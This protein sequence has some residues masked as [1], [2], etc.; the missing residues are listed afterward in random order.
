MKEIVVIS[1]KG[2]TG[3]TSLTA[4]FA[5][6]A[7]G[8]IIVA[9]C[10]VDAADMH[11]FLQ[12][13][14]ANE[15]DFYS[16]QVAVIDP[17]IC[18]DCGKCVRTCRF[19][20]IRVI[21]G[22]HAVNALDCEGCGYCSRICPVNAITDKDN[23][24]GWWYRSAIKTGTKMLHAK[25]KVGAENSGKLVAKVKKEAKRMAEEGKK[26]LVL[27]DG[28]P[29]TGCP[30][31]SS[32]SGASYVILVTEPTVS[33]LHDLQR[34]YELVEKFRIK[35]GCIVNKADLNRNKRDDIAAYLKKKGI[36][37]LADIPYDETFTQAMVS[38]KTM[39]EFTGSRVRKILVETWNKI[40]NK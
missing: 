20:A 11:V 14:F 26:K 39:A 4:S 10:D 23:H 2:G 13:D 35:A 34:V 8:D 31:V 7:A 30:V 18:T 27:V 3:K 16:G 33:G 32:L 40:V 19:D 5:Y 37:H 9:D 15:K 25:M 6:L 28:S 12:P 29:G 24:V 17:G 1:G 38:G 22:R 21:N 36:D